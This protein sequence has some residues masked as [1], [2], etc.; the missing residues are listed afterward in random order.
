MSENCLE[1][2]R[3][4]VGW[5]RKITHQR[6]L[7][8]SIMNGPYKSPHQAGW[9][10]I[11]K[12]ARSAWHTQRHHKNQSEELLGHPKGGHPWLQH[13]RAIKIS[14]CQSIW[15]RALPNGVRVCLVSIVLWHNFTIWFSKACLSIDSN[16]NSVTWIFIT[17]C[18]KWRT[19][20]CMVPSEHLPL[21]IWLQPNHGFTRVNV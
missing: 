11:K 14:Q 2:T 13:G 12:G 15:L 21:L 5:R 20:D 17:D 1:L 16:S 9:S 6:N 19:V 10:V 7:W 18:Q 3:Q 8:P 4:M